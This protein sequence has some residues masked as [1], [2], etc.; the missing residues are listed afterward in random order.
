M[1]TTNAIIHRGDPSCYRRITVGGVQVGH[2]EPSVDRNGMRLPYEAHLT[3][4][5]A[6]CFDTLAE[7]RTWV[8]RQTASGIKTV[9]VGANA[10][11][12]GMVI[13]VNGKRHEAIVTVLDDFF[14]LTSLDTTPEGIEFIRNRPTHRDAEYL[15]TGRWQDFDVDASTIPAPA[16]ET[17]AQAPARPTATNEEIRVALNVV[18]S[19]MFSDEITEHF[20]FNEQDARTA[21]MAI[22]AAGGVLSDLQHLLEN[23]SLEAA[24][25]RLGQ[26]GIHDDLAEKR[27]VEVATNCYGPR[28]G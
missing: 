2:L 4:G 5:S 18:K 23:M 24:M 3:D 21:S 8:E 20:G 28:L 17:P 19:I 13:V 6:A 12:P 1:T 16:Y 7:A 9:K 27:G 22:G 25:V 26:P 14:Y 11:E 15:N 10:L